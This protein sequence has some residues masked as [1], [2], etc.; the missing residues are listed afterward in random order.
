MV[1]QTGK[2]IAPRFYLGIGISGSMHHVGGIKD[3]RKI[4][5]MNIDSKAPMFANSDEAI[6]ADLKEVLPRLIKR[7]RAI[8]GGA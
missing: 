1:G 4:I 5:A 2:A 7:V 8:T 3:S 6:V